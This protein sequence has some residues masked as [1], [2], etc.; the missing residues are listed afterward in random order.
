MTCENVKDFKICNDV[1]KCCSPFA[2]YHGELGDV[3]VGFVGCRCG[4]VIC[5]EIIMIIIFYEI[6][7][8]NIIIN[9]AYIHKSVM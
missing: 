9:K 2:R 8:D 1:Q 3:L 6:C 4:V 7:N 5:N